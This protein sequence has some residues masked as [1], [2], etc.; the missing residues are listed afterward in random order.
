MSPAAVQLDYT[1]AMEEPGLER[2]EVGRIGWH[3]PSGNRNLQAHW[4]WSGKRV[5]VPMCGKTR[6]LVWLE[7]QGNEVVGIELSKIA[8]LAFF[9]ENDLT[10]EHVDGSLPGYRA[11]E[12][13]ISLYCGDFF[14]YADGPAFDA[15]YDRGA[16]V[17][18]HPDRRSRY[19][20]HAR[21]LLANGASQFVVTVEYDQ[22]VC[23][24]P[25]YS[26][27][28]SEVQA[29]WPNLRRHVTV[30]DIENA[31]PKFLEAGLKTMQEVVWRTP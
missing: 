16:L 9:E 10:F 5:L 20:E 29:Y 18:L 4:R 28:A 8:I 27:S 2:W 6:D 14:N 7:E 25:P 12:R 3:E 23:D 26:I 17:A 22:A 19:A 30:E 24:G 13:A 11:V 21:S 15:H 31:P 1:E